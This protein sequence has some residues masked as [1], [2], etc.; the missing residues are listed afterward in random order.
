MGNQERSAGRVG[1]WSGLVNGYQVKLEETSVGESFILTVVGRRSHSFEIGPGCG[2]KNVCIDLNVDGMCNA[3]LFDL[4]YQ[5]LGGLP[6]LLK[7]ATAEAT[8]NFRGELTAVEAGR[9]RAR[10]LNAIRGERAFSEFLAAM[11]GFYE[12]ASKR[13]EE[14]AA[15]STAAS[16]LA[17]R[18][19][20]LGV[21]QG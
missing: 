7:E 6:K 10:V 18:L 20:G 14:S 1:Q 11:A 21:E 13:Y 4:I 3:S 15:A 19:G 17:S 2:G 8:R 16:G 5:R 12:R 9:L